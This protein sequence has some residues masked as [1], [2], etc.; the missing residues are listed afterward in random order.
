MPVSWFSRCAQHL[1]MCS[2]DAGK[3][4][5]CLRLVWTVLARCE[6]LAYYPKPATFSP[7]KSHI[8]RWLE[9]PTG[10]GKIVGSIPGA[11]SIFFRVFH[12]RVLHISITTIQ[13]CLQFVFKF[14]CLFCEMGITVIT[15]TTKCLWA[16]NARG[17][18]LEVWKVRWARIPS[19]S[20]RVLIIG[21]LKRVTWSQS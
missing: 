12:R 7:F 6:A 17:T 4:A 15:T 14:V 3:M 8:P 19:G 11:G 18:H 16:V 1:L 2:R 9:Q 20:N 5:C 13:L 21:K 10:I